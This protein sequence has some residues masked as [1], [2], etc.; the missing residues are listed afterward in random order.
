MP[1]VEENITID[2]GID[3][4][5]QDSAPEA[6]EAE[7]GSPEV[8]GE[9]K[10][11]RRRLVTAA[12][13]YINNVPHLG[14]IVGSHLPADIFARW[15]RMKGY[16]TTFIGGSDEH[17]TPSELAAEQIGIP[18]KQFCDLLH[19]MHKRI[20]EWFG[21][22]Y[23]NYSRTGSEKHR[24]IV[25]R[26]FKEIAEN[27]YISKQT[28]KMFFDPQMGRFLADRYVEGTCGSCGFEEA[29]GD[30]CEVCTSVL[31]TEDLKNPKSKLTG[32]TPEMKDTEHLF[33][34]LE[35]LEEPL[36]EW[37]EEQSTWRPQVKSIAM[38]WLDS[39]LRKRGI[40]RDLK[41][42]IPVPMEGMDGKVLYVWFEAPIAYISF[43]AEI[44]EQWEEWW[45]NGENAAEIYHFLGKDNIPFHTIFWPAILK[46]A[47]AYEMPTH[48][49]G[50]QY[51][52][53]EGG[54]FSKSKKRGVFCESMLDSNVDPDLLRVALSLMLPE[55]TDSEFSWE[56][57]QTLANTT[58]V[59]K[60]SNFV[61]RLSKFVNKKM[62]GVIQAPTEADLNDADKK[63]L[64]N[65]EAAVETFEKQMDAVQIRAAAKTIFEIASLGNEYIDKQ[66]PWSAIKTDKRRAET[67]LYLCSYVIRTV[68]TVLSP[69]A[70]DTAEKMWGQLNLPNTAA[71]EM[72]WDEINNLNSM[73]E[74]ITFNKPEMLF[75]R[76]SEDMMAEIKEQLSKITDLEDFFK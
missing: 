65:V 12:L 55:K 60:V 29:S 48:V 41:H 42:G 46:A 62:G 66:A 6:S 17:G 63:L 37:V 8:T 72:S 1:T 38:K 18:H 70:P 61:Y 54:K 10:Q 49:A 53:Y 43:L 52:N 4:P 21:I 69:F 71:A 32:A 28:I 74:Q 25:E 27:G 39:G 5:I 31:V 23:D 35:A 19:G 47:G 76:L 73:P 7:T 59:N 36:R 40:T 11:I 16:E 30:Q 14:H 68:A 20:Y 3:S 33:L 51:L 75:V 24:E 44:E 34:D 58:L 15:S 45:G 22:S 13:P 64:E 2:E 9:R 67:I 57:F 50:M 26:I 56:E